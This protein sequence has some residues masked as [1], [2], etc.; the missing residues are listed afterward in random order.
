MLSIMVYIFFGTY[1]LAHIIT[2]SLL[3]EFW[4]LCTFQGVVRISRR[5]YF[6]V[7]SLFS[8]AFLVN[9]ETIPSIIFVLLIFLQVLR[10]SVF[11]LSFQSGFQSIF[12]TFLWGFLQQFLDCCNLLVIYL[13]LRRIFFSCGLGKEIKTPL[14]ILNE[15]FLRLSWCFLAWLI[16]LVFKQIFG[17]HAIKLIKAENFFKKLLGMC[18]DL[19]FVQSL[20]KVLLINLLLDVSFTGSSAWKAAGEELVVDYANRPN[21]CG[22]GVFVAMNWLWG[23]VARSADIIVILFPDLAQLG[24]K[25]EIADFY[26][27]VHIKKQIARF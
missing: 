24:S 15:A 2:F 14:F 3:F 11:H 18:V 22:M 9:V 8:R 6:Q 20:F 13:F 10:W 27:F 26:F 5:L 1:F 4:I 7:V 12:P 23:H 16:K 25:T 19:G 17:L 21:I